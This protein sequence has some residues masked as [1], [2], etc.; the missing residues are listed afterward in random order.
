[1]LGPH[2]IVDTYDVRSDRAQCAGL[3]DRKAHR[4]D[5]ARARR[6]GCRAEVGSPGLRWPWSA[7]AGEPLLDSAS[8]VERAIALRD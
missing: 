6:P 5:P 2:D 4:G 7:V 3:V 1:V 8:E